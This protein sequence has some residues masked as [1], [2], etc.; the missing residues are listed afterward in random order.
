[1]EAITWPTKGN[2]NWLHWT[3]QLPIAM[4]KMS[5]ATAVAR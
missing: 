5:A 3:A 4:D 1:L 2:H